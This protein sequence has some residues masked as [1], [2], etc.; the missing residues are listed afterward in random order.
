MQ[1]SDIFLRAFAADLLITEKEW[2]VMEEYALI[3]FDFNRADIKAGFLFI[4]AQPKPWI[5]G[6]PMI[7]EVL[8]MAIRKIFKLTK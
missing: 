3:L 6:Q 2:K 1:Y 5:F 4:V 7:P 8:H